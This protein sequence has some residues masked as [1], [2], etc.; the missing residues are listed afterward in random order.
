MKFPFQEIMISED[1]IR[2]FS[3]KTDPE[4]LIWHRDDEDREVTVI[5]SDGWYF[6]LDEELPIRMNKG[7][8]FRIPKETWHRV[9]CKSDNELIVRIKTV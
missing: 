7:D 9:L 6:Q 2:T 8:T 3:P 4:E 1:R 5:Q